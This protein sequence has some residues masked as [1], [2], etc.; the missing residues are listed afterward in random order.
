MQRPGTFVMLCAY[1]LVAAEISAR[2]QNI[3][4]LE[5]YG[6]V[7]ILD[8]PE[9]LASLIAKPVSSTPDRDMAAN[10]DVI[11]TREKAQP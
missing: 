1:L 8:T 5:E 4:D 11:I 9:Q 6:T 2:A 10:Y 3:D 7:V